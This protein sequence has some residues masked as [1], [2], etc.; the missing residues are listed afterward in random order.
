MKF[1]HFGEL[2]AI[3]PCADWYLVPPRK[4]GMF[5]VPYGF[6]DADWINARRTFNPTGMPGDG[7]MMYPGERSVFSSIR[8]A[9]CR[10]AEEDYEYLKLAAAKVGQAKVDAIVDSIV[11]SLTD[12][13]HDAEKLRTARRMIAKIISE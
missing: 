10:D 7:I 11:R 12:F 3:E 4:E 6:V 1:V 13:S 5:A 2:K 9:Q 8:L